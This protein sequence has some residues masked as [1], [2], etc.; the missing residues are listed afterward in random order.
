LDEG[1]KAVEAYKQAVASINQSFSDAKEKRDAFTAMRVALRARDLAGKPASVNG[2]FRYNDEQLQK[3]AKAAQTATRLAEKL[4]DVWIPAQRCNEVGRLKNYEKH[5]KTCVDLMRQL[6]FEQQAQAH[7]SLSER[8][9]E[10][11]NVLIARQSLRE[12]GE[13]YLRTSIVTRGIAMKALLNMAEQGEALL[14]VYHSF[15]YA[16]IPQLKTQHDRIEQK[17]SEIRETYEQQKA[18]LNA[19]W[20]RIY[21]MESI[22]EMRLIA[23]QVHALLESGLTDQDRDDFEQVSRFIDDFV[24]DMDAADQYLEDPER[25]RNI[26]TAMREKYVDKEVSVASLL[27]AVEVDFNRSID[28]KDQLWKKEYL[29][30]SVMEESVEALNQWKRET[31]V[32]PKYLSADTMERYLALL[33]EV[34]TALTEK[35]LAYIELLFN[36]LNEEEKE[37]CRLRLRI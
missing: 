28:E 37:Q 3:L 30:K 7:K 18:E 4:F 23:R 36:E 24:S 2:T 25:Y 8:E 26:I 10:H 14:K 21:T 6:G 12:N 32:L 15:D 9:A 31:A 34:D 27:D 13:N 35:K 16:S 1:M 17:V 19:V 29:S 11:L 20:D 5:I 22:Q 33:Q